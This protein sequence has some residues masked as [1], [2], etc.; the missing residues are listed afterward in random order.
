ME[1]I[2]FTV[3]KNDYQL[4]CHT[5][6]DALNLDRK[7]LGLIG[8]MAQM[9]IDISNEIDAFATLAS[10]ISEL[11]EKDFRWLVETTLSRVTVVNKGQKHHRLDSCDAIA[12]Q[13]AANRSELYTI[14][15]KVW[16]LEKLSPFVEAPATEQAGA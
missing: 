16:K 7:V 12:E 13:F 11:S 2:N 4:I 8:R 1:T 6:F 5:G 10:T 3:G 9:G 14:L 15:L